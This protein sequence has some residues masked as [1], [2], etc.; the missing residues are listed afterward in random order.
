MYLKMP[1]CH[2]SL[3]PKSEFV[4]EEFFG[5]VYFGFLFHSD[6]IFWRTSLFMNFH[7][8]LSFSYDLHVESSHNAEFR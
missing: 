2:I 7:G 6:I 4:V 8:P 3:L 1:K 5:N